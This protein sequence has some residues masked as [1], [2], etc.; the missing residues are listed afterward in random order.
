M[1]ASKNCS[2]QVGIE[3]QKPIGIEPIEAM[4]ILIAF[5]VWGLK[6]Q[7][8]AGQEGTMCKWKGMVGVR[9]ACACKRARVLLASH[10]TSLHMGTKLNMCK[11][12]SKWRVVMVP[13]V[14]KVP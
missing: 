9:E 13:C 10:S 5:G 8:V 4:C 7:M 14:H 1:V 6:P 3:G 2:R 11:V 12:R